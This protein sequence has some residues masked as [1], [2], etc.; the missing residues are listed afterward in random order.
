M[1]LKIALPVIGKELSCRIE[2]FMN[3]NRKNFFRTLV[4]SLLSFTVFKLIPFNGLL[5]KSF[6][7]SKKVKV[8][9][10]PDAVSRVNSGRKND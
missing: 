5:K 7:N 10:N 8:K 3:I 1:D 6:V 9:I 2:F 4:T